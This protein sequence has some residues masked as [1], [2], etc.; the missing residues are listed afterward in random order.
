MSGQGDLFRSA[1]NSQP[2]V[3]A[4]TDTQVNR[5]R[6]SALWKLPKFMMADANH[7]VRTPYHPASDWLKRYLESAIS[8]KLCIDR[9]CTTC[10]STEFKSGLVYLATGGRGD[11]RKIDRAAAIAVAT[12]TA[13]LEVPREP[14]WATVEA[15][16]AI[17]Y[18]LWTSAEP[19]FDQDIAPILAGS[20]SGEV[21]KEMKG[22]YAARQASRRAHAERTD[23]EQARVLR[24]QKR[25]E[26]HRRHIDRLERKKARDADRSR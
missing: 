18:F 7:T 6:R 5:N 11:I 19:N 23:P 25:A 3:N 22:H 10:G 17:I 21:L 8:H 9:T 20:W 14:C 16:R 13:K 15:V 1:V 24:E 12:A 2:R 26:R 4:Q